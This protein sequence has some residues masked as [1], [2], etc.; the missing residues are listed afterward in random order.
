MHNPPF[1]YNN[2][3]DVGCGGTILSSNWILTSESCCSIDFEVITQFQVYSVDFVSS[4]SLLAYLHPT[5]ALCLLKIDTL[6]FSPG[7]DFVCLPSQPLPT[8]TDTMCFT[9]VVGPVSVYTDISSV[10]LDT[11]TSK[12]Q[13]HDSLRQTLGSKRVN[14]STC[15]DDTD[16]LCGTSKSNYL[17][18]LPTGEIG[19]SLICVEDNKP[20][21][22]GLGLDFKYC[23]RPI[24]FMKID[25]SWFKNATRDDYI[26]PG[27]IYIIS[28]LS[29]AQNF[30]INLVSRENVQ[31]SDRQG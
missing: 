4:K 23:D 28:P 9:A 6:T 7:Q 18:D 12:K 1:V 31:L 10:Y 11:Y 14:V 17:C 29:V 15:T 5:K 26:T 3:T 8:S 25:I 20:V 21:L 27:R 24:R 19:N 16:F 30:R 13:I 2:L 22:Y